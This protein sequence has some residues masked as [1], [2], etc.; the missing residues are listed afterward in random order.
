MS[1]S[2]SVSSLS[3]RLRRCLP[4]AEQA[5]RLL[6]PGSTN[7]CIANLP[8]VALP[9]VRR[10]AGR[11]AE[12]CSNADGREL[13]AAMSQKSKMTQNI[14]YRRPH[15]DCCAFHRERASETPRDR[16]RHHAPPS[17]RRQICASHRAWAWD[18]IGGNLRFPEGR[19]RRRGRICGR[20]DFSC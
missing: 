2:A 8:G 18:G 16:C 17:R 14:F 3:P 6:A 7:P 19:L 20:C 10:G 12:A 4:R 5:V 13:K 15:P 11:R 1:R 9:A